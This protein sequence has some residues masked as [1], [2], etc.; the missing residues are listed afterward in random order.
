MKAKISIDFDS[1]NNEIHLLGD[2]FDLQKHRYAWRYALD[3]LFPTVKDNHIVIPVGDNEPFNVMNNVSSMLKKYGFIEAKSESTEQ[4]VI[5]Y[6][7]EER[8]FKEFSFK[9]LNIKNNDCE[10]NEF[11]EFTDAV[12]KQL[13]ARSL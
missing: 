4:M 9:A 12:A 5:D 13:S 6:Y 2:I 3:Y 7:E 11:S 8:R 10:A 1:S